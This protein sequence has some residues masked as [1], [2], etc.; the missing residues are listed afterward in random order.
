MAGWFAVVVLTFG[1]VQ[2]EWRTQKTRVARD[3][4][5]YLLRSLLSW[6]YDR[7]HTTPRR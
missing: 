4:T 1:A 6:L 2:Y 5:E 3:L 7:D